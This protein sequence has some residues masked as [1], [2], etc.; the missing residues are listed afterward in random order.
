MKVCTVSVLLAY[1]ASVY[2]LASVF[3]ILVTRQLGTPFKNAIKKYPN[4]MKIKSR[5]V[6]QRRFAFYSGVILSIA[7]LYFFQPFGECL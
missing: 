7:G 2:I 5:A 3:Y 6:K 4:L 1:L